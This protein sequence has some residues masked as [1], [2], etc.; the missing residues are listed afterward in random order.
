LSQPRQCGDDVLR[1]LVTGGPPNFGGGGIPHRIM[2]NSRPVSVLRT[3]GVIIWKHARHWGEVADI[4]V[5]DA[6]EADDRLLVGSDAVEIAHRR[7]LRPEQCE[8]DHVQPAQNAVDDRAEDRLVGGV[9]D[10]DSER[11]AKAYAVFR[12]L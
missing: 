9:A 12:A 3:T 4:A 2:L 10:G 8:I 6:K 5:D 7:R 1:M 11:A